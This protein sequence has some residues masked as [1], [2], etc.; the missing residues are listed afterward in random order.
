MWKYL[1]FGFAARHAAM[2][3]QKDVKDV[4]GWKKRTNCRIHD[5]LSNVCKSV[6]VC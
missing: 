3:L 1:A 4:N 2:I 5:L 6:N